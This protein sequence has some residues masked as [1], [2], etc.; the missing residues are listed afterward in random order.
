MRADDSKTGIA[1]VRPSLRER[2]RARL[3]QAF[4]E[5]LEEELAID[6]GAEKHERGEDR[7]GYRNGVQERE[8]L[9]ETGLRRLRI[10]RARLQGEEGGSEEWHSELLPRYQRRTR[11]VDEALLGSYL[12]GANTRRIRGALR[13]LWGEKYLSKSAISR[14]VQRLAA[15]FESWRTRDLSGEAFLCLFLDGF[16][17]S[18]RMAKRVVRVP[19]QAVLGVRPDG[20]KELLSLEIAAS[21]STASWTAV[22]ADLVSRKLP[23]PQLVV[24]DGNPGLVR[25]VEE[26]WPGVAVQRCSKHK[27][28]NLLAKAPKHSHGELKRDYAAIVR[29]T[30]AEAGRRAYDAFLVKWRKLC[31]EMARSLEEAGEHLLTFTRFPKSMWRTLRTTNQLERLNGEFRRR[32]KTQ[33]SFRNETSALTLLYG[34]VAL[35]QV[36]LKKIDGWQQIKEVSHAQQLAA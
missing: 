21:E 29:P 9:T 10:P 24:L 20:Q 34:L 22:V 14:I 19:V 36:R 16:R 5:L 27:L 17:L 1:R 33:G 11:Q 28:E 3:S 26:T 4:E 31:P 35:G 32:T 12:S 2:L 13:P 30:S 8:V 23:A 7:R 6:L 18:V 25:A 15:V